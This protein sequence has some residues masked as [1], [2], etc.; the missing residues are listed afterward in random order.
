MPTAIDRPDMVTVSCIW[1]REPVLQTGTPSLIEICCQA[2]LGRKGGDRVTPKRSS[3]V[4][5]ASDRGGT[6]P[7]C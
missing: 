4:P 6:G 1:R 3:S 2:R 7:A 5:M